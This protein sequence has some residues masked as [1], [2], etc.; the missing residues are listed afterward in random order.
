M[1]IKKLVNDKPLWDSFC[2]EIDRRISEVHRVMEQSNE[3]D[4]M[5]R[6]QGQAF[7][8]RK[9]KQLRDQVNGSS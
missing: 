4:V 1:I 7:A 6:L 3:V 5:Y 9:M 8:L 2:E